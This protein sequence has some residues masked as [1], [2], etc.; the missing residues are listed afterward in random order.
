MPTPTPSPFSTRR[1]DGATAIGPHGATQRKR[2]GGLA[3]PGASLVRSSLL[4]R[5]RLPPLFLEILL[6]PD[7]VAVHL[8]KQR[9]P[10]H[11]SKGAGRVRLVPP[12][13]SKGMKDRAPFFGILLGDLA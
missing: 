11:P 13:R 1:T 8:V 3:P 12:V 9:R 10:L 4:L 2:P 7:L 6:G 5:C